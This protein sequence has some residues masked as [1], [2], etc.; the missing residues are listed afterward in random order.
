MP[1]EETHLFSFIR[2]LKNR[3]EWIKSQGNA[4]VVDWTL[5][6]LIEKFIV[7]I[8]EDQSDGPFGHN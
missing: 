2:E 8:E 4:F 7:Y 6:E 1:S 3:I 5:V